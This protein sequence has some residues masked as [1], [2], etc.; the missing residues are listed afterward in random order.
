[1]LP[2]VAEPRVTDV[3]IIKTRLV[4]ED[5]TGQVGRI[6]RE[7]TNGVAQQLMKLHRA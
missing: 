6:I 1:M 4:M 7:M 2:P 5:S 3:F